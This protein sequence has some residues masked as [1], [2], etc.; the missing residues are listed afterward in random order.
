MQWEAGDLKSVG[1]RRKLE[2]L[3]KRFFAPYGIG[4]TYSAVLK[5]YKILPLAAHLDFETTFLILT[6]YLYSKGQFSYILPDRDGKTQ[7]SRRL[8]F[9][10]LITRSS[11]FDHLAYVAGVSLTNDF[12]R[13]VDFS[14]AN[15]IA[16]RSISCSALRNV[17]FSWFWSRFEGGCYASVVN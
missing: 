8:R 7:G 2:R 16:D 6:D 10:S 17:L 13:A 11:R 1:D 5:Q 15:R 14:N 9:I 3:K 4:S 12:L